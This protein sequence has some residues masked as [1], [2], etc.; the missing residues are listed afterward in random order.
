MECQLAAVRPSLT[1]ASLPYR[2]DAQCAS[3][4]SL[5][6]APEAGL[7]FHSQLV[8]LATHA[9]LGAQDATVLGVRGNA[10]TS[11]VS[12]TSELELLELQARD[13]AIPRATATIPTP[14]A[15][16]LYLSRHPRTRPPPIRSTDGF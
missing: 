12:L 10:H 15:L 16:S 4:D 7:W 11:G 1:T 8:E 5:S 9:Q 3:G 6:D 14:R 2:Y 13:A